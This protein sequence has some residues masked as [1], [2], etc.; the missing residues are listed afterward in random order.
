M[1]TYG[2]CLTYGTL[3]RHTRVGVANQNLDT[4]YTTQYGTPMD[5][6][7]YL[8]GKFYLYDV[9]T[10]QFTIYSS[11][12]IDTELLLLHDGWVYLRQFDTLK[13]IELSNLKTDVDASKMEVLYRRPDIVPN[14]HHM[15]ITS[16]ALHY[17]PK[18]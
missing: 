17:H 8:L 6:G 15:F 7:G 16:K 10:N 2:A 13:R 18:P 14:I 1:N 12:E 4:R 9:C 11:K 5:N 3:I